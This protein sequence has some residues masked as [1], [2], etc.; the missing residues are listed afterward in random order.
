MRVLPLVPNEAPTPSEQAAAQEAC[1]QRL[2]SLDVRKAS[3]YAADEDRL[4]GAIESGFETLENFN[5]AASLAL[6][7]SAH[8]EFA[9]SASRR[10]SRRREYSRAGAPV[11][12]ATSTTDDIDDPSFRTMAI[13]T[14]GHLPSAIVDSNTFQGV[15][16]LFGAIEGTSVDALDI[17]D[18]ELAT[19]A[20]NMLDEAAQIAGEGAG[21]VHIMVEDAVR[22]GPVI[23]FSRRASD[24][25]TK[26]ERATGASQLLR[27][28]DREARVLTRVT[29]SQITATQWPSPLP[30][31]S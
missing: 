13:E 11:A 26:T 12:A 29:H 19:H 17:D 20:G 14:V 8:L 15:Q 16:E 3:C 23:D 1:Q 30:Q 9:R 24:L 27:E 18:D 2:A 31:R 5:E 4:R 28:A 21:V 7:D 25:L 6:L 10:P 22:D